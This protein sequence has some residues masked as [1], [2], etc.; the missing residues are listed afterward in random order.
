[1]RDECPNPLRSAETNSSF[2]KCVN[3][4][5]KRLTKESQPE[6]NSVKMAQYD[7]N[8]ESQSHNN[9]GTRPTVGWNHP[10]PHTNSELRQNYSNFHR[11]IGIR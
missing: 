9:N 2:V 1:M 10:V 6:E 3:T 5:H 4:L 8:L 11:T 7:T